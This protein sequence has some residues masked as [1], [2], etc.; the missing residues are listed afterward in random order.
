MR[1]IQYNKDE[2]GFYN[3]SWVCWDI[4]WKSISSKS[5]SLCSN[6]TDIEQIKGRCNDTILVMDDQVARDLFDDLNQNTSKFLSNYTRPW[7]YTRVDVINKSIMRAFRRFYH[8]DFKVGT[9]H[10]PHLIELIKSYLKD[11][12]FM[13]FYALNYSHLPFSTYGELKFSL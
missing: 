9:Y 2:K 3:H 12:E 7:T 1:E 5:G 8:N 6:V 13:R 11:S 4:N 10:H